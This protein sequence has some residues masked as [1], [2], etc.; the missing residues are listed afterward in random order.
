VLSE[1]IRRVGVYGRC[2]TDSSILLTRLSSTEPDA[3][4]WTLPGGGMDPGETHHETLLREF[5]EETALVPEIGRFLQ[6]FSHMR[7]ANARR[8]AIHVIQFVYEVAA[9]G[10]P[11]V[12]EVGGSTVEAAWIP[13]REANSL[14]LVEIAAWAVAGPGSVQSQG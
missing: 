13:L 9:V 8:G 6:S 4:R 11:T 7:P 10:M 3:G 2:I 12:I 5:V 14:P 1:P